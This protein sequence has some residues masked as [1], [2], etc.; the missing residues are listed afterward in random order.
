[1]ADRWTWPSES[2]NSNRFYRHLSCLYVD[3]AG[4]RCTNTLV[5]LCLPSTWQANHLRRLAVARWY[6]PTPNY[7]RKWTLFRLSEIQVYW[8]RLFFLLWYNIAR[9]LEHF[10]RLTRWNALYILNDYISIIFVYLY[11]LV[12]LL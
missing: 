5:C 11:V 3:C 9:L 8:K 10:W 6:L 12:Y 7:V 4:G 1:M 2:Q